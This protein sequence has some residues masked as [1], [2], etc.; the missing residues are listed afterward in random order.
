L[1]A[2]AEISRPNAENPPR[3]ALF[4]LFPVP[5]DSPDDST[6]Q[7]AGFLGGPAPKMNPSPQRFRPTFSQP[8]FESQPIDPSNPYWRPDLL[9]KNAASVTVLA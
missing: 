9:K 4:G 8:F 3:L 1:L 6:L 5:D 7:K 2:N